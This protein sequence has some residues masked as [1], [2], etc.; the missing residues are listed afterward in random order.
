MG[1]ILSSVVF[2]PALSDIDPYIETFNKSIVNP[3]LQSVNT[4]LKRNDIFTDQAAAS[5]KAIEPIILLVY[6]NY[7]AKI[8]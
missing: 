3:L 5:L 4:C 7:D 2:D 6:K 8:H 1:F